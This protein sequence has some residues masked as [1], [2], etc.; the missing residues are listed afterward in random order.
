MTSQQQHQIEQNLRKS[1][2][3]GVASAN[4]SIRSS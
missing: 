1:G 4:N 2:Q 3:S